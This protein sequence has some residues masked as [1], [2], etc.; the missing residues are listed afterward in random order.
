MHIDVLTLFPEIFGPFLA[1]SI[2][3][4]ARDNG[5]ITVRLTNFRDFTHDVHRSVDDKPYGGGPGMV[6]KCEPIF[7]AVRH[8][9]A[10]ADPPPLRVLLTPQGRTLDQ[11]L[12]IELARQRALL[13]IC[14][15]YEGFDERIRLGLKPL[16]VSVGDYVL[17]GGEAAAMVLI[18]VV[19]RLLPGAL[20]DDQSAAD[21]S[22][23]D[24]TLEYPHYTRPAEFE[25]MKVPDVLLSGNHQEVDRWRRLQRAERT[26]QRRPDLDP[27]AEPG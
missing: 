10:D 5:L 20:G 25:N 24:G 11:Q 19:T 16:E 17:S 15:R 23:C 22:F 4:R 13:L 9:E 8:V 14:G 6:L 7:D 27:P 18:D 21:E 12:A 26:R 2:V 3:G 1:T